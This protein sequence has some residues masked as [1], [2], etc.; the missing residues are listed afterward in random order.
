MLIE[1]S[2]GLVDLKTSQHM[3]TGHFDD[4]FCEVPVRVF[5]PF[6]MTSLGLFLVICSVLRIFWLRNLCHT[7]LA[8]QIP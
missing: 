5:S 7:Y 1:N 3:F 8:G 4:L 2:T 6:S